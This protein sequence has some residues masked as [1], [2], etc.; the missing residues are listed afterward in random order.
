MDLPALGLS[1]RLA[2]LTTVFLLLLATPLAAW[3]AR[4]PTLARRIVHAAVALP[5]VLPCSLSA[6]ICH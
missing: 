5:L 3:L 6:G 2:A 1:L 4:A